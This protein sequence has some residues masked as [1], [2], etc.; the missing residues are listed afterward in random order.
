MEIQGMEE[1]LLSQGFAEGFHESNG[2]W[3]WFTFC[4]NDQM[5]KRTMENF[6][7]IL[8]DF[9]DKEKA[10]LL[11]HGEDHLSYSGIVEKRFGVKQPSEKNWFK[12]LKK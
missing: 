11:H 12:I 1:G 7:T 8:I 10:K 3:Q 5:I 6:T 9:T 4:G 2:F